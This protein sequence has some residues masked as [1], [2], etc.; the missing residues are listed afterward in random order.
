ME[1][2]SVHATT[3]P[4]IVF[5]LVDDQRNTTLG[6]AGDPLAR[7]PTIDTLAREGIRFTNAFVTTSICAASRASIMTGLTERTHGYTFGAPPVSS[8]HI[9]TSYPVQLRIAGYQTAF[10]G[11]FGFKLEEDDAHEKMFD[12]YSIRDRPYLRRSDDGEVRH[13]D[14]MNT[15]EAIAFIE[16]ASSERPF[17]LS[18][19]FSSSHAED[20]DKANHYP[21][22]SAVEGIFDEVHFP[23]PRLGE[24]KIFDGQPEFLKNSLNRERYFWR[25]DTP[26]KY[27]KNMRGYY[28][29]LA[30]VD[31]MIQR[32]LDTLDR[33]G[34]AE[35]TVVVYAADNGYYM[36]DRGFA[37]KWSHYEE[38]LRIPLIVYDPRQPQENRGRVIDEM[39]L[40]I[41]IAA[42]VLDLANVEPPKRYQGN[43][44]KPFLDGH[45]SPDWRSDFFAEHRMNHPKIPTWEGVR[46]ERYVYA[47]YDGQSPSYEFLHDLQVDPGQFK[48]FAGEPE[49]ESILSRMRI[50][51]DAR[52]D[53]YV[54]ARNEEP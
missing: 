41:D 20:N 4:N 11:K 49:Y 22:I 19:S 27:Q 26:E 21:S 17:S 13:I 50:R 31:T 38:S 24:A 53:E 33:Q 34:L 43:S 18:I 46:G 48:N 2:Q 7:T 39:V 35:N 25:W 40:N 32:V 15:E 5:I 12:V 44:L 8:N 16:S 14:E 42:T 47:R 36:G 28:G 23:P 1:L 30:G 52:R 37:G 51:C 45:D 10:F 9:E 29:L 54:H 3:Q 6:V